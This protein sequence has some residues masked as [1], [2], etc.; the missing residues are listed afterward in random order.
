MTR[1]LNEV[2]RIES[3][4]RDSWIN[5]NLAGALMLRNELGISFVKKNL[6]CSVE[7]PDPED[8]AA[9]AEFLENKLSN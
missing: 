7:L 6:N 5:S 3:V 1:I 8:I 4:Q 2:K 9:F